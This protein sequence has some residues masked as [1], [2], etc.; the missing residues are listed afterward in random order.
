MGA[1]DPVSGKMMGQLVQV[2][3]KGGKYQMYG[4]PW[5]LHTGRQ[6]GQRLAAARDA[7]CSTGRDGPTSHLT[8]HPV[9][10]AA[11]LLHAC[12]PVSSCLRNLA[13]QRW[14]SQAGL[15]QGC[16]PTLSPP[17]STAWR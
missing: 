8:L 12:L 7:G 1:I 11:R 14:P 9:H 10:A 5:L 16:C 13:S 4:K 17:R 2:L 15:L 6:P 3:G